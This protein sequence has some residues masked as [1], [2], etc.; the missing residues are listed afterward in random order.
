MRFRHS[1]AAGA[2]VALSLAVVACSAASPEAAGDR[3]SSATSADPSTGAPASCPGPDE[4]PTGKV[5]YAH[6]DVD[7]DW[8]LWLMDPDGTDRICLIDTPEADVAPAWSP[9]GRR[10]VFRGGD[11][12]YVAESDGSDVRVLLAAGGSIASLSTP[13]WSPDGRSIVFSAA[14]EGREEPDIMVVDAAGGEPRALI[15][16]GERFGYV[17]EPEWSPD[18]RDVLFVA[19]DPGGWSDLYLMRPDGSDVRLLLRRGFRLTGSGIG[20][21]PDGK[22][23]AFQGD[24]GGG[25]LFLVDADGSRVRRLV[26]G[27]SVGVDLTWSPDSTTVLWGPSDNGPGDLYAVSSA[28]GSSRVVE[29]TAVAAYPAWQPG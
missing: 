10:L 18:G 7:G 23:I 9:D 17:D 28:G 21:S 26:D 16:S 4:R 13:D 19:E 3:H 2:A 20:W 8:S 1:A 6:R 14:P 5:A 15:R 29:D 11:D 22:A 24:G 27:C 12:L 25:C